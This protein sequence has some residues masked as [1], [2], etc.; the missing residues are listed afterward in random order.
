LL[1]KGK[2]PGQDGITQEIIAQAYKAIPETFLTIYSRLL[3]QG[4]HPKCWRHAIGVAIPKPNKPSYNIPKAYRVISLLKCLG[5]VSERILAKR[6]SAMAESGPLLHNSQLG[7]RQGKSAVDTAMLLTDFIQTNKARHRKT[8]TVFLDVKGAFDHVSKE[9]LLK[10]LIKLRLPHSI[11][12]WTKSFLEDRVLQLSFDGQLET[13]QAIETGVPQG[14]PISPI[15]FLIY[16]HNLFPKLQ[17]VQVLSYID[18]IALSTASTSLRKNVRVLQREVHKLTRLGDEQ[19]VQFDLAKTELLHFSSGKDTG[20]TITLLGGKIVQPAKASVRWLGVWFD[21]HLTFK[22]HIKTRAAQALAA[23]YR[24]ERLANSERGLTAQ[25]LRTLYIACVISIA[26]YASPVWWRNRKAIG[27]L[28][29][30]QSKAAKKILG[31]FRTAPNEPSELEA[32][33]LPTALRLE[34]QGVQ[35]AMRAERLASNHP[36]ATLLQAKRAEHK[37]R[38]EK[39]PEIILPQP[40]VLSAKTQIQAVLAR[41]RAYN[42]GDTPTDKMQLNKDIEEVWKKSYAKASTKRQR[43]PGSYFNRFEWIPRKRI[44]AKASRKTQSAYYTL[45]LGHGYFKSYLHRFHK[46]ASNRCECGREETPEHLLLRCALYKDK[47]SRQLQSSTS[48]QAAL[49]SEQGRTDALSFLAATGIA[50][51]EWHLERVERAEAEED[52]EQGL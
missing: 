37:A 2:T 29:A 20:A 9:R 31:V 45:K 18:D 8:S 34:K 40:T 52:I 13:E 15:L 41:Q 22:D 27:A 19:A 44:E 36:I 33:L 4:Y 39:S 24:M 5:K 3:S 17:D 26:D 35:Y 21:A 30:I 12:S 43:G 6:L 42:K 1:V 23:F 14:S 10:I 11:V 48:I 50:T 7:G 51:R 25:S 46:T 47:R 49:Q 28:N 38:Q 32:A 16:I